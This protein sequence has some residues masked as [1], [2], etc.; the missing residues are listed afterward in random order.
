MKQLFRYIFIGTL[1]LIP[2][3]IV[4]QLVFWVQSYSVELFDFVSSYTN[5]S[6][7]TIGIFIFTLTLLAAVGSSIEKAGKSFL[8][9]TIDKAL[10]KV[11]A[12]GSIYSV[13]KKITALFTPDNKDNKK[14]VVLVE[15]PKSD[16]WVPAYVLNKHDGVLVLFVPTSPNP[17]S[18]YTII[19][20]ETKVKKTSY[21]VAQ[22]S[23]FIISMG[24]D[25]VKKEEI[26]S[27]IKKTLEDN[28]DKN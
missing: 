9:S 22:A 19:I 17:T 1:A 25:F 24:A 27:I 26:T 8:I 2:L 10:A 6:L 12:L 4:L 5:D 20:D 18:G 16:T 15:Y 7:F 11:P 23:Q 28:K 13:I 21:T 14:E 3:F